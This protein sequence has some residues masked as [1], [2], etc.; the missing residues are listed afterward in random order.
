MLQKLAKLFLGTSLPIFFTWCAPALGDNLNFKLLRAGSALH[1][2]YGK[3]IEMQ[4]AF[5]QATEKRMNDA[6]LKKLIPEICNFYAPTIGPS[7]TKQFFQNKKPDFIAVRLLLGKGMLKK[8]RFA[9]FEY[10]N[11]TCGRPL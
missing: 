1:S 7:I 9:A 8:Y 2:S 5:D 10:T 3:G 6:I 4:I 11:N